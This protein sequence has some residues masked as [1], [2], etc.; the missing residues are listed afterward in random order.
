MFQNPIL[1]EH[2][3]VNQNL[4]FPIYRN[5]SL[6]KS[7]ISKEEL[8]NHLEL[9]PLL[10]RYPQNLSGGEK[11]RV[12]L[13]RTI[14]K[15]ADYLLLDEPMSD[16]DIKTK[17][18]ILIFLKMINKKFNIPILYVS[19]SIEEISQIADEI[20]LLNNGKKVSSGSLSKILNSNSFQKLIGKF[21]S[22]SV[23]EGIL[24]KTDEL[25]K[26]TT[27]D[28]NGQTLIVPG[29]PGLIGDIVRVR[30]RSRDVIVSAVK[31]NTHIIENQLEG[32]ITKINTEKDTAF[33]ELI[34]D[35]KNTEITKKSQ[36]LRARITTYNLIKMKI[37]ENKKV[38][39]YISSVSID[40][41]AYQY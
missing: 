10:N 1:F 20:I 27:L 37:A 19:H 21:E 29:R 22:S 34:I 24:L 30:I 14:L 41:Q 39:V 6:K 38:F 36:L 25:M 11:L 33:S 4:D 12:A 17:A 18:R 9:S 35:L 31:I 40:R 3:S 13:A 7:L 2:M 16:L 32:I 15:Q 26:I 23:L 5:K 28:I 8:I